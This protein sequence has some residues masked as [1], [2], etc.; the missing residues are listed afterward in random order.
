MISQNLLVRSVQ[1]VSFIFQLGYGVY[2]VISFESRFR[3]ERHE[4]IRLKIFFLNF[5][6]KLLLEKLLHLSRFALG[7]LVYK[8]WHAPA[9][10]IISGSIFLQKTLKA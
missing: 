8:D 9:S 2:S 6:K 3:D 1:S 5:A 4:R 10:A 7:I